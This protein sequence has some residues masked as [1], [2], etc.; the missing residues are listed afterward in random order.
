M[1]LIRLLVPLVVIANAEAQLPNG[2]DAR[3]LARVDSL[4]QRELDSARMAGAVALVLRDGKVVYERAVGWVDKEARTPMKT[5]AIFRIASQSKAITSVAIMQLVEE[6]KIAL[7]DRVSRFI[8]EYARTT[9]AVKTDTGITIVP[10]KRQITIRDLLTQT[11]G[12]SYGT[13]NTAP[14]IAALYMAKGFGRA[15]AGLGWYFADKDEP[16]CTSIERLASLPFAGQPGEAFIYGYATDILG[17]VVERASGKTFD[18]FLRTRL[19]GPLGMKDTYF[20]VPTEQRSR[21]VV[22]YQLDPARH[23]QRAPA[24]KE[25]QGDYVDGPRRSYSGGAGLLSTAR[26]Y[27]RFL[28]MLLNGGELD[29]VRILSRKAVDVMTSD[30]IAPLRAGQRGFGFAFYVIDRLGADDT[31]SSIGTWGWGGAYGTQYRVDPKERL[32]MVF[33]VNQWPA[34][35]VATKFPNLVYQALV[36]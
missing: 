21:L 20:Y 11:A 27:A 6:G 36:K 22:H 17:C 12:I 7:S 26:D 23:T 35:E 9:V 14:Q 25:G 24:G 10:A 3:R 32:V 31:F 18:E 5:D 30:Q 4:M 13:E 33:M 28:Q 29:G 15:A 8:P 34:P 16:I 1:R 19:T 2:F